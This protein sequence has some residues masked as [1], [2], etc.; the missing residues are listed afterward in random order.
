[1]LP[2]HLVGLAK[3]LT[4]I[5]I[6]DIYLKTAIFV[7][8]LFLCFENLAL[9]LIDGCLVHRTLSRST[10]VSF[11]SLCFWYLAVFDVFLIILSLSCEFL[12]VCNVFYLT[13][14]MW[15]WSVALNYLN[16]FIYNTSLH[17][18]KIDVYVAFWKI[19]MFFMPLCAFA[20]LLSHIIF[21]PCFFASALFLKCINAWSPLLLLFK[22][23][24][25]QGACC[26]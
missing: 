19:Y 12:K 22:K 10:L 23:C 11:I 2:I 21:F 20:F 18:C 8:H 3:R 1:M 6:D 7:L 13:G 26:V 5:W 15:L 17:C 25:F 24:S 9:C 16:V 14:L 4:S